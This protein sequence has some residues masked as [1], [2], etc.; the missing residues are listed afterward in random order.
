MSALAALVGAV[1]ILLILWDG[2]ETILLPRR[3]SGPSRIARTTQSAPW[4]LWSWAARGTRSSARRENLLGLFAMLSMLTLLGIWAAGLVGG[5]AL[6][7]RALGS[8][9]ASP[10]GAAGFLTDLYMSGTTFF[11]LGLGD[12]APATRAARA[13]T[14]IE[15]G[16]GVG[17][18]ALVVSYLPVL[19]QSFSRRE[20]RIVML[21]EWA[22]SPPSAA[23][24]LT[25]VAE[26]GEPARGRFNWQTTA[27]ARTGVH[28]AHETRRHPPG[29]YR[30]GCAVRT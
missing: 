2:F 23:L 24:P 26:A 19:Y 3:V 15:A 28:G 8:R 13:V 30:F 10:A 27:W 21:D 16:T 9:L 5:F 6:L 25:R 14:V 7:H 4:R 12:V 20:A 22:G 17:F 11:T 29:G 18:L 1:L